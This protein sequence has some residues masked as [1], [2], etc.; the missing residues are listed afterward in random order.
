MCVAGM[1][2]WMMDRLHCVNER[3]PVKLVTVSHGGR[4]EYNNSWYY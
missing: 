1:D 3:L 2:Q 4:N